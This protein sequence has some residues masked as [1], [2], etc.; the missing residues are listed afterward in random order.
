MTG[1]ARMTTEDWRRV[2]RM[3]PLVLPGMLGLL[4]VAVCGVA[5]VLAAALAPGVPVP[6]RAIGILAGAGLAAT[7]CGAF[8]V[9]LR[10]RMAVRRRVRGLA[11]WILV[12]SDHGLRRDAAYLALVLAY[13]DVLRRLV[14]R[15][16]DCGGGIMPADLVPA[17]S[18]HV[19]LDVCEPGQCTMEVNGVEVRA[20][21]LQSGPRMAVEWF[22]PV[23]TVALA[24]H[25][26][27]HRILR[28]AHPGMDVDEQHRIMKDANLPTLAREACARVSTDRCLP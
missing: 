13:P 18:P 27:G 26:I 21:G 4:A 11:G 22:R 24:L 12:T 15:L 19:W 16:S 23:S 2:R 17:L 1:D 20:H 25:E 8:W 28:V 10:A 5:G 7:M 3:Y 9:Q 6:G 14:W